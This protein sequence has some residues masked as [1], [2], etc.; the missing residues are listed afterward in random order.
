[1]E[2]MTVNC[3]VYMRIY[4]YNIIYIVEKG[5]Y[6]YNII[7]IVERQ[8]TVS[9]LSLY[10]SFVRRYRGKVRFIVLLILCN[11]ALGCW[12]GSYIPCIGKLLL[13]YPYNPLR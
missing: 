7:H 12:E 13:C 4:I 11:L 1:M 2:Q 5:I 10:I 6:I 8:Y 3:T 9:P